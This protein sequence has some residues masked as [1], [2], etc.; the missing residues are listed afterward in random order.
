VL[1]LALPS[2]LLERRPDVAA[3]ERRVASANARIGVAQAGFFP[4]LVI[5]ATGGWESGSWTRFFS[6]PNLFWSV[7]AA[8]AQTLFEG[9][10]RVAAKEQAVANYDAA[11]AAYRGSV[12]SALQEVEDALATLRFLA[13]EADQQAR[14]VAAAERALELAQ[15]RYQGGI[16]TY[17][18]VVTAQAT[19]LANERAAVDLLTRRMTASVGLVKAVGGGWRENALPPPGAILSRV[20]RPES[21]R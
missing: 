19:A 4:S 1:P 6:A 12:L 8:L 18:E 14:A 2:E 20:S 21:A 5:N 10:K 7:G 9:G 11:V 15:N 13:A 17:L 3:A 16:T